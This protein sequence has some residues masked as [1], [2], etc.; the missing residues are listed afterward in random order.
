MWYDERGGL[1]HVKRTNW[2]DKKWLSWHVGPGWH[3]L[4][5]VSVSA[6]WARCPGHHHSSHSSPDTGWR[7]PTIIIITTAASNPQHKVLV[8]TMFLFSL[9]QISD[10]NAVILSLHTIIVRISRYLINIINHQ[11]LETSHQHSEVFLTSYQIFLHGKWVEIDSGW[12]SECWAGNRQQEAMPRSS[13]WSSL[14]SS[15][16]TT[17]SWISSS[18]SFFPPQLTSHLPVVQVEDQWEGEDQ[19]SCFHSSTNN[20][21]QTLV[22]SPWQP[23]DCRRG[24]W[25]ERTNYFVISFLIIILILSSKTRR[26]LELTDWWLR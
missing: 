22:R 5:L 26:E 15:P 23:V 11:P 20:M 6:V 17:S 16:S 12:W 8:R 14:G 25:P 24:R 9:V 4:S 1:D 21:N 19:E 3:S 10:K 7:G 13:W 2:F 18:S